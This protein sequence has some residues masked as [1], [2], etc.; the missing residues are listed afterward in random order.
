MIQQVLVSFFCADQPGRVERLSELFAARD[1]SWRESQLSRLG[2]RFAGVIL[3]QL[4]QEQLPA[5]RR[6][7][8]GLAQE[9]I[10]A[11]LAS[12]DADAASARDERRITLV[13]P[14]RAGIVRELTHALRASGC[15]LLTME[16]RLESAPMSGE[17]LFHAS[18][19]VELLEN[20]R[21][22]ALEAELEAIAER[23][24]L[25]IDLA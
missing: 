16:T 17:P 20:C 4:P 11:Q 22:E 14:D 23:M 2:G 12:A 13:G 5:L 1:G 8:A 24:T 7:L 18:C 21:V 3:L 9:G 19:T 25:H 6:D 15:N 10:T